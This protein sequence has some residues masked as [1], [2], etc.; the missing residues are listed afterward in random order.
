MSSHERNAR[1][2]DH[3]ER[4]MALRKKRPIGTLI[5]GTLLA[6][7][8]VYVLATSMPAVEDWIWEQITLNL[9]PIQTMP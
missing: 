4:E 7:A 2:A 5:L 9:V 8:V 6:L 3:Y 1:P